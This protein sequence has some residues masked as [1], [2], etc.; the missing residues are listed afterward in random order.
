MK[1]VCLLTLT[2]LSAVASFQVANGEVLAG[3]HT[4]SSYS[5]STKMSDSSPD[6]I[7]SNISAN[8]G[9]TVNNA[10]LTVGGGHQVVTNQDSTI[11][12]AG[13][14]PGED[15]TTD[16]SVQFR[17]ANNANRSIDF[18]ITNTGTDELQLTA[19]KFHYRKSESTTPLTTEISI[20]HLGGQSDLDGVASGAVVGSV[21]AT[22]NFAWYA[23]SIDLTALSDSTLAANESA[24]FQISL[25]AQNQ[26]LNWHIDNVAFEGAF[27]VVP[28]PGTYALLTGLAAFIVITLKRRK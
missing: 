26:F 4:W 6:Y 8:A 22:S 17:P 15:I 21:T 11:T 24:A 18:Q 2:Y 1:K 12:W 19:F 3:W 20:T 16:S 9:V 23:A 27:S 7:I 25:P 28:E 5:S 10:F 14:W 13:T